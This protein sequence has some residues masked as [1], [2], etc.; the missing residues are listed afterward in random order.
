M[1]FDII[2]IMFASA[3]VLYADTNPITCKRFKPVASHCCDFICWIG[4]LGGR[5]NV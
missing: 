2:T 3:I 4:S 5:H 1:G